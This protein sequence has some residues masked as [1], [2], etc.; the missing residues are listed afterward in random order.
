MSSTF[1]LAA[2]SIL[3]VTS[4]SAC[5]TTRLIPPGVSGDATSVTV[6]NTWGTEEAWPYAVEHCAKHGKLPK[7]KRRKPVFAIVYDCVVQ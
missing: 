4:L 7:E 6:S 2:A 3:L 5:T 1:K